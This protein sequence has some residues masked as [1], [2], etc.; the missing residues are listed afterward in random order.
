MRSTRA[1]NPTSAS[2]RRTVRHLGT[3]STIL[4]LLPKR[5]QKSYLRVYQRTSRGSS[6]RHTL[7]SGGKQRSHRCTLLGDAQR[8]C[9]VWWCGGRGRDHACTL[10]GVIALRCGVVAGDATMSA[11]YLAAGPANATY[12]DMM[13]GRLIA[14]RSICLDA[15]ID[16]VLD[17]LVA[18]P[19]LGEDGLS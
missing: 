16:T 5:Y 9:H 15:D 2:S 6:E 10:L 13:A 17:A 14:G 12:C 7:W 4:C 18:G 1:P 19:G 8:K 11:H 3:Y